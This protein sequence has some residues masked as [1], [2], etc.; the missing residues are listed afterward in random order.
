MEYGRSTASR[1]WWHIMP[2]VFV[3]YSLAYVDRANYGLAAAAGMAADLHISQAESSLVGSLFLLGYFIFQ[4]PG[5]IYGEKVSVKKL[6]IVSMILWGACAALTGVIHQMNVLLLIRFLMGAAEA[7]VMPAMLVYISRWFTRA[8]RPLANTLFMLGNPVTVLWMSVLSAYLIRM[9]SWRWMFVIEGLPAVIW[10]LVAWLPACERPGDARWMSADEKIGLNERI[11]RER[12]DH[13]IVMNYRAM[14]SSPRVLLLCLQYAF[15]SAGIFGFILWL[16]SILR[17][18]SSV[19][20]VGTGWLAA[21]P[22]LVAIGAMLSI[23][24]FSTKWLGRKLIVWVCLMTGAAAFAGLFMLGNSNFAL[25]FTLLVVAGASMYAP[26]GP[27]WAIV[28]ELMGKDIA[29]GG[30]ALINSAGALGA[31]IGSYLI[32][33]NSAPNGDPGASYLIMSC[34]LVGAFVTT[35]LAI[36]SQDRRIHP[37]S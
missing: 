8:E 21:I 10:A 24:Y 6:T 18:G 31:F 33:R 36:P 11:E 17:Y 12:S 27:Y 19:G 15:W 9:L 25:S 35:L 29:G 1:R 13:V 4:I 28:A 14:F 23:S 26:Y 16:P 32:G 3:T 22:Y 37:V 30:I 2:L 5:A 7:A 34:V 20:I